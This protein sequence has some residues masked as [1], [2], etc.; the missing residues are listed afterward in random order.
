MRL[1]WID[2]IPNI[3]MESEFSFITNRDVTQLTQIPLPPSKNNGPPPPPPPLPP[4][5]K[6]T[7]SP[8]P[9]PPLTPPPP[10]SANPERL[11]FDCAQLGV[12]EMKIHSY[13]EKVSKAVGFTEE[14]M[15][16][17]YDLVGMLSTPHDKVGKVVEGMFH[18][19]DL[20]FSKFLLEKLPQAFVY[21]KC[22][23]FQK[24]TGTDF[25]EFN[26]CLKGLDDRIEGHLNRTEYKKGIHLN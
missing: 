2:D 7:G 26:C 20:K 13:L 8:M 21:T 10:P 6:N 22:K 14:E 9:P 5:P 1:D 18:L 12:N 24:L 16:S 19:G 23:K 25:C 4:P 15:V 11:P 3:Q 17:L